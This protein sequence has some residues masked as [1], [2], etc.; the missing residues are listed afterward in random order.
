MKGSADQSPDRLFPEASARRSKRYGSPRRVLMMDAAY[1]PPVV[2]GKEKQAHLLAK[3]LVEMNVAVRV[4]TFRHHGN[5]TGPYEGVLV[6]RF[7]RT[8]SGIL[9]LLLHV[10]WYRL[11]YRIL[12]VHTPS[13]IGLLVATMGHFLK[14]RVIFKLPNEG[15]VPA[16]T[17]VAARTRIWVYKRIHTIVCLETDSV[18]RLQEQGVSREHIMCVDNGVEIAG[19]T[20]EYD[21]RNDRSTNRKEFLFVGRLVA[22]KRCDDAINA[23]A[24]SGLNQKGYSLRIVG[25][26]PLRSS[27]EQ[28]VRQHGLDGAVSF[29]GQHTDVLAKMH[30]AGCLVLCSDKEGMPNVVLEAMSMGLPVIASR[31]GAVE[32]LLGPAGEEYT[33]PAGDISCLALQMGKVADN[34]GQAKLYGE[35][36]RA[37]CEQ[38]FALTSIAEHYLE[39]YFEADA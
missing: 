10:G 19:L 24:A 2:G 17:G 7:R 9:S 13:R 35:Q 23:F 38:S 18:S 16:A 32:R 20:Q 28:L 21:P 37:R 12:H 6:Q 26:G 22:Q 14:Y 34:S 29:E 5:R 1:P 25:D 36:L 11:R 4:L 27:L 30:G 3:T 33:F 39:R 31:V 15:L 8:L